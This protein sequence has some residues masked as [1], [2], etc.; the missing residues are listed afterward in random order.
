MSNKKKLSESSLYKASYYLYMA[1]LFIYLLI[2]LYFSISIDFLL[3]KDILFVVSPVIMIFTGYKTV[4]IDKRSIA[5]VIWN[6]LFSMAYFYVLIF[7]LII[8]YLT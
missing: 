1:L 5:L 2:F 8:N 7:Q 4:K 3:V 6:S